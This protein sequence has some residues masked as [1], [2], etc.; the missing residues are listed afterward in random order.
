MSKPIPE[1]L[2]DP[3]AEIA[4]L[5]AKNEKL[6][7]IND[8]LIFRI[9]EGPDNNAAYSAFESSVHLALQVN[10]KTH[11]LNNALAEL[12]GL[13]QQL[14]KAN[15]EANLFRQRFVDAIESISEAFVLLN[16]Q[17]NIIY[18]NNNFKQLWQST[19]LSSLEGDNYYELK[20]LGKLKGIILSV[21]PNSDDNNSVYHL[22]N[23]RW[24]QLNEKRIQDGGMVLLFTDI[25]HI[26]HAESQRYERAIAQKNKLLQNLIDN[27]SQGVL[28]LN[29]NEIPEVWNA[30]FEAFCELSH[31]TILNVSQL[32]EFN[33]ITE[34]FLYPTRDMN[35][36]TQ[37]LSNGKVIDVRRHFISDG[38]S[39]ITL[40]DITEQ[41]QYEQ[42]LRES[43]NW[44]RT[45]TDN[46]PAMIAYV[47]KQKQFMFTNK[48]Y[49]QWYGD[50]ERELIGQDLAT[51][52]LFD[53]WER[54]SV[55]VNRALDG[56]MVSF[57]SKE[58]SVNGQE[59]YL[60]K[61]YVPNINN[62]GTVDGFFVLINDIT[63]RMNAAQALQNANFELEERVQ[64]RTR[65]LENEIESRKQTQARLSHAIT[66]A[67]EATES[68]SKFLAAVSHD[69]LQPLNAAQ[70][71][72]ASLLGDFEPSEKPLLNSIKSSL[73]DLENLIVTL[74]DISKLDAGVIKPDIQVFP[75][76][77]LLSN[78]SADYEKISL[79]HDIEFT[80]IPTQVYVKSD[81]LLLARILRNYLSNAIRYAKG[82]KVTLGCRRRGN[83]VEIQ[84]LDSGEG[85]AQDDL[86][87]I[88]KEFKRLKGAVQAQQ[89]LGLGLAIVDKMAKVLEHDIHVQ[90]YLGR[91]S[92]FSVSLPI[93]T[94]SQFYQKRAP[95]L[96]QP[97]ALND[98]RV[99]VIDNDPKICD[100]MD[101]LLSMWGCEVAVATS[102]EVLQDSID[103]EEALCDILIVD[104]H[105]DHEQTGIMVSK[106]IAS[107]RQSSLPTIMISANYS[108]ALQEECKQ[109]G[110]I[111]LNK[112]VKPLKLRMTMQQCLR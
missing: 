106:D 8:A 64:I 18:Q 43:E 47:N 30:K 76:N 102:L 97:Q 3:Q 1:T 70:L 29:K 83:Q 62:N 92:C 5:K 78:I 71:F 67:K 65:A 6:Q 112:P 49:N 82:G 12:Q 88:F 39:I 33:S 51:S 74:V 80:F 87:E 2:L 46:V 96:S 16:D 23:N 111:L 41:H 66:S 69:L 21:T 50:Q 98:A 4:A 36:H 45:I 99:W 73:N 72:A 22:S 24:Y 35:F 79:V 28:L 94:A 32:H 109:N 31:E 85:I 48:V 7:K 13:N 105:L 19:E 44:I 93:V 52:N 77:S 42:S 34:V 60:Q 75:L 63:E 56:E 38:Q 95:E 26:K 110:I 61:S 14:S 84:V 10:L 55:F 86:Q 25:T 59:S 68:K 11:E 27:L 91:G 101:V 54:I 53:D 57:E 17:G 58:T 37:E 81:S 89:S 15:Q 40:S 90:S 103:I 108:Q 104:Y 107:I 100:A 20:A 9:E